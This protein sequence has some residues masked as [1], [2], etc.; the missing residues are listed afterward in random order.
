MYSGKTTVADRIAAEYPFVR[1]SFAKA[2]KEDVVAMGFTRDDVY[3]NKPAPVRRLLQA[4]G[5]AKRSQAESYWIKRLEQSIHLCKPNTVHVIDDVRFPNEARYI[6]GR[7][8]LIRLERTDY[9]NT[10]HDLSETAL[11]D[12]DFQHTV[13]ANSGEI[14]EMVAHVEDILWVEGIIG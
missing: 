5:Q 2:L 11:D 7:G 12:W 10:D 4:Y 13:F 14:D 1:Q 8:V 9:E 6:E 3:I